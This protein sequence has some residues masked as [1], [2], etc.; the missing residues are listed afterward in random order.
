MD[1]E[2]QIRIRIPRDLKD[3]VKEMAKK[4]VRSL[5]GQIVYLLREAVKDK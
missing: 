5:N 3:K 2:I 4:E 1:D